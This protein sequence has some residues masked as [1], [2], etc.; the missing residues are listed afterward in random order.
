MKDALVGLLISSWGMSVIDDYNS[1]WIEQAHD[2]LQLNRRFPWRVHIFVLDQDAER[3]NRSLNQA[4]GDQG[5]NLSVP[6]SPTGRAPVTH[7]AAS[8]VLKQGQFDRLIPILTE[9]SG[10]VA[11]VVPNPGDERAEVLAVFGTTSRMIGSLASFW[12]CA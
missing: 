1:Q 5:D 7:R 3:V 11:F 12:D 10:S 4:W 6:M 9:R 2:R 8:A